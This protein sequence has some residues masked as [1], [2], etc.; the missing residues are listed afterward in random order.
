MGDIADIYGGYYLTFKHGLW[1]LQ[2]GLRE[3]HTILLVSSNHVG[4]NDLTR[5]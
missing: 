5:K 1:L 2:M 4:L 3:T